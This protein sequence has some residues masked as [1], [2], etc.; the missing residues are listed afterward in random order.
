MESSLEQTGT[1][2]S[3]DGTRLFYREWLVNRPRATVYIV[4]GLGE[5][6]GRYSHVAARMNALGIAVRAHDHRGHGRSDGPRGALRG[7]DDLTD[8][9]K[10]VLD[11]FARQQGSTP[12]LLGHS[13]GGLVAA[14][15]A[16]DGH[17]A[18]R[19]LILSSPALA[20][21]MTPPQ[22]LLLAVSSRIAPGLSV[23][24]G[25]QVAAISH[26]ASVVAAYQADPL[27]HGRVTPRLVRFMLD[28]IEIAQQGADHLK[29]PT[30][31]QVAGSD[32]LVVPQGSRDF[33]ER[34]PGGSRT[35]RWYDD[36]FHEIYN[37][38]SE[39]RARALDDLSVWL[40]TQIPK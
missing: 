16:V 12:F 5:H 36:S 18:L 3:A 22:R 25:L 19:G 32:R 2:L 30:L 6:S 39:R 29:I 40:D 10:L 13:L 23:P 8:D 34:L 28:S 38:T 4:H 24:N 35:L 1:L 31:L 14:R 33:Y 20:I 26:D 9:L 21:A 7:K 15:F 27:V 37:E 17:S 11:D